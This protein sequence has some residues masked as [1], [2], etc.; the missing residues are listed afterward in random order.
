MEVR[1]KRES[2]GREGSEQAV[3]DVGMGAAGVEH[4]WG[5]LRAALSSTWNITVMSNLWQVG[6]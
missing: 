2:G 6:R 5:T 4:L 1:T 3:G